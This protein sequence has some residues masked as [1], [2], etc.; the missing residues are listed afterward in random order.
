MNRK[1]IIFALFIAMILLFPFLNTNALKC[2]TISLDEL[3]SNLGDDGYAFIATIDNVISSNR[4]EVTVTN[5]YSRKP[6]NKQIVVYQPERLF[7][8]DFNYYLADEFFFVGSMYHNNIVKLSPCTIGLVR[9]GY[10][11]ESFIVE[12]KTLSKVSLE[13]FKYYESQIISN[14]SNYNKYGLAVG[15]LLFTSL[16]LTIYIRK[17]IYIK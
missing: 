5:N 11:V 14:K 10:V 1:S 16:L 9:D 15:I 3:I 12:G 2:K 6:I 7:T 8:F 17:K 13:K 4:A